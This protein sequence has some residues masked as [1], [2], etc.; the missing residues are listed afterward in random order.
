MIQVIPSIGPIPALGLGTWRLSGKQCEETVKTALDLGYR[1]IDTA[2]IYGNHSDVAKGMRG[3]PREELFL[4]SKIINEELDPKNVKKSCQRI[5][6]ELN[7]PYLDLLLIHWPSKDIPFDDTLEAMSELIPMQLVKY[8]GISN[9][10]EGH[11][12]HISLQKFPILTNQ[13]EMH[14]FLQEQDL[15]KYCQERG[16]IVTAYR[17]IAKGM[18]SE[19]ELLIGIGKAH[20]KSPVQVVLRWF[21]QLGIVSIPKAGSKEHLK[22]NISIFD[23]ELSEKD[24]REIGKLEAGMRLVNR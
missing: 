12:H 15:V 11:L 1:H 13:I 9:F 24:M 17:P 6:K 18:V 23:F 14:P 21:Y 3:F 8:I 22:E 20:N 4:V 5:L 10:M 7:T 19:N 16:I 2:D